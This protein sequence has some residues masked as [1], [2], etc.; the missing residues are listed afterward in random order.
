MNLLTVRSADVKM[1][2]LSPGL[3]LDLTLNNNL[4]VADD[5][6]WTNQVIPHVNFCH[7]AC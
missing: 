5:A 3:E 6:T 2:V 4:R 7:V 1:I